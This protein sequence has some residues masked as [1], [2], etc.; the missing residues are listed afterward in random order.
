M[1]SLFAPGSMMRN[2]IET[3]KVSRLSELISA[4]LFCQY[5]GL[6]AVQLHGF[7]G[8][9]SACRIRAVSLAKQTVFDPFSSSA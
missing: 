1:D 5:F 9:S 4:L 6:L 2:R 8:P 7:R 3:F